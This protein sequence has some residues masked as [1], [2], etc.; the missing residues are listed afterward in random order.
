[1][2]EGT[3]AAGGPVHHRRTYLIDRSFQLRFAFLLAGTGAALALLCGIWLHQAHVHATE[4]LPLDP[5]ARAA[6]A[7]SDRELLGALVGIIALMSVTLGVLGVV[8]TH[9]VAG[10]VM[11]LGRSIQAFANG[12]LPPVRGLRR[13]D[14]LQRLFVTFADGVEAFRRR[15][16]EHADLLDGAASSLRAALSR[17][18]ELGPTAEA[19]E[20]AAR[21]RRLALAE[22]TP[23]P[24]TLPT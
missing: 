24:D 13:G 8:V 23:G 10:P 6:V 22:A 3:A 18:P 12:R 14:D 20:A 16:A 7:R 1:M 11:V 2:P 4:L 5:A 17:V 15:E 21:Q 19:L 9:R